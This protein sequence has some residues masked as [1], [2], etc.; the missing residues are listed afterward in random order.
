MFST[1]E[2]LMAADGFNLDIF[3][4][5]DLAQ[6]QQTRAALQAYDLG[7]S[8]TGLWHRA[9]NIVGQHDIGVSSV[10]WGAGF[11]T[12]RE[13]YLT[14]EEYGMLN[15]TMD[16]MI[17]TYR[18]AL[19]ARIALVSK[20]YEI[21][22]RQPN[23]SDLAAGVQAAAEQETAQGFDGLPSSNVLH[24]FQHQGT[25]LDT[26][27]LSSNETSSAGNGVDTGAAA[28]SSTSAQTTTQGEQSTSP[29]TQQTPS[30]G[31]HPL[32]VPLVVGNLGNQP[33][34]V[35]R[36]QTDDVSMHHDLVWKPSGGNNSNYVPQQ[37]DYVTPQTVDTSAVLIPLAALATF[38]LVR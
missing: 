1:I 31:V 22:A 16:G 37:R 38:I 34:S 6:L 9:Y 4:S 2:Q 18:N 19:D 14:D 27:L 25:F 15:R 28:A 8:E 7:H 29:P 13:T 3:N 24:H 30:G 20:V 36:P 10:T 23:L 32:F 26:F 5:D 21:R 35:G 12:R 33:V 17:T 11:I